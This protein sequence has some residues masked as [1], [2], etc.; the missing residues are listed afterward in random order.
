MDFILLD[1][2][3]NL[4]IIY[5]PISDIKVECAPVNSGVNKAACARLPD[6]SWNDTNHI[7]SGGRWALIALHYYR[8]CA[9]LY[10]PCILP[11]GVVRVDTYLIL[12]GSRT[13]HSISTTGWIQLGCRARNHNIAEHRLGFNSGI[14]L[15]LDLI[16]SL[17]PGIETRNGI[18]F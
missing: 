16:S 4:R 18:S 5:A 11:P 14:E 10:P 1:H 8:V 13:N 7:S 15:D 9:S 2:I 12:P 6:K 3:V 17:I